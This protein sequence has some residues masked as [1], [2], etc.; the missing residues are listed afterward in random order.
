MQRRVE[1]L[2]S[3]EDGIVRLRSPEVG[4]FTCALGKDNLL[5]TGATAGMI[6]TLGETVDLVVPRGVAG[7]ITSELP[8][9]VHDP[10]GYGDVL[11][12][13]APL[14]A[15]APVDDRSEK[16][17]A[18]DSPAFRSPHSGRLWHRPSPGDPPFV[19]VGDVITSGTSVGLIEVMKTFT[20]LTYEAVDDL[21][22]TARVTRILAGDGDEVTEGD[23]LLEIE[24]A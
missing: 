14:D 7:R 9:R 21:P 22:T 23:P 15:T 10:V 20:Y 8:E 3:E 19:A 6:L 17:R 1:L 5:V 12:E 16:V 4:R 11:Y 18:S 13:L 2:L 24:P